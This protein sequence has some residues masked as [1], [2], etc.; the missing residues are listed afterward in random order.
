MRPNEIR[1]DFIS[2]GPFNSFASI[3]NGGLSKQVSEFNAVLF[4]GLKNTAFRYGFI[5]ENIDT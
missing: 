5:G 3:H 4:T 1:Y 2:S